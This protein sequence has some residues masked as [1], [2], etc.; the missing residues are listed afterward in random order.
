MRTRSPG[1]PAG[2]HNLLTTVA[3]EMP[4]VALD[5]GPCFCAE[6]TLAA[7]IR[8]LIAIHPHHE[9]RSINTL[10]CDEHNVTKGPQSWRDEPDYD[11]CP[12]CVVTP[13][14]LCWCGA[15]N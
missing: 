5:E 1:D 3:N 12:D 6:G 7:L 4:C 15:C 2:L 11:A 13:L 8:A 14:T 10:G 9:S